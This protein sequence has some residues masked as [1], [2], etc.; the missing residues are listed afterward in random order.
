MKMHQEVLRVLDYY[1][2]KHS[3]TLRK[4]IRAIEEVLKTTR[5]KEE[6]RKALEIQ[7]VV[8][9]SMILGRR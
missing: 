9:A 4:E 5:L 1:K 6:S 3:K 7:I 2:G 8:L